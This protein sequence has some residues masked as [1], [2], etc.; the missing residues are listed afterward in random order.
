MDFSSGLLFTFDART[1]GDLHLALDI[2]PVVYDTHPRQIVE[3]I[4]NGRLLEVLS[5][6]EAIIKQI[7]IPAEIYARPGYMEV[8]LRYRNPVKP[9]T[10][11]K[12][13]PS[14]NSALGLKGLRIWQP[15][16]HSSDNS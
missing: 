8:V 15:G 2:V 3:V 13:W 6:T 5:L 7:E 1:A 16:T 10:I 9:S 12:N 11:N 14:R 4:V